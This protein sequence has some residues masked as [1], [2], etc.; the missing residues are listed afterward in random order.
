MASRPSTEDVRDEDLTL[1][2]EAETEEEACTSDEEFCSHEAEVW[3]EDPERILFKSSEEIAQSLPP[4]FKTRSAGLDRFSA[5]I[6]SLEKRANSFET[7]RRQRLGRSPHTAATSA[8]RA[9]AA[10]TVEPKP[11]PKPTSATSHST[12]STSTSCTEPTP[13]P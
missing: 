13:K 3:H 8:R 11:K 12:P 1:S 9:D 7:K 5:M 6:L 2:D 10:T 4:G